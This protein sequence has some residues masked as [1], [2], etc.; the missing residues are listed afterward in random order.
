M[1]CKSCDYPLWN[2]AARNCP[3]CGSVFAPSQFAFVPGSVRFLCP[4]CTTAYYGLS[5][6]GLLVPRN[7][8]CTTCHRRIDM[9]EMLLMPAEGIA[10]EQ[11]TMRNPWIGRVT[12]LRAFFSSVSAILLRPREF[13]RTL[14]TQAPIGEAIRFAGIGLGAQFAITIIMQVLFFALLNMAL[15]SMG[16][17]GSKSATQ[18][19][20]TLAMMTSWSRLGTGV[21]LTAV[22]SVAWIALESITAHG[23]AKL[24]GA[25]RATFGHTVQV[26]L[27]ASGAGAVLLW[28]SV[29]PCVGGL[30]YFAWFLWS[31][32]A[33]VGVMRE[34]HAMSGGSA[35]AA[36]IVARIVSLF[37]LIVIGIATLFVAP[38]LYGLP[39]G[40]MKRAMSG[41]MQVSAAQTF[42]TVKSTTGTWPR[43]P[44]DPFVQDSFGLMELLADVGGGDSASASIGA[45]TTVTA[46]QGDTAT[47]T[48][49]ADALAAKIPPNAPFRLGRAVFLYP[50][51]SSDQ[52]NVAQDWIVVVEQI[53]GIFKVQ[54]G[55]GQTEIIVGP[56]FSQR[57]A[58]ENV[59]RASEGR[60]PIPD[61]A[62]ITD[63]LPTTAAPSPVPTSP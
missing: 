57:L 26:Y 4:H 9:D 31:I 37:A 53:G 39:P 58:E 43:T 45:I 33:V 50:I 30:L 61:L 25:G 56:A 8:D 2:V 62:T 42:G 3:E 17:T 5:A 13:G 54:R 10:A 34:T 27:Y 63:L 21:L 40:M 49:V 52:L 46:L 16:A 44:I 15:G 36:V 32:V 28:A 60:G 51:A 35:A 19:G 29:I 11:L 12:V 22:F 23:M 1:R 20:G 59:R 38:Q 55:D 24:L 18:L 41:G 6:D 14:P 7:F 47:I 48:A